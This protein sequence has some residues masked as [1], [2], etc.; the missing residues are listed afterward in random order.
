MKEKSDNEQRVAERCSGG[1]VAEKG[2]C[3]KMRMVHEGG[4][5]RQCMKRRQSM[6]PVHEKEAAYGGSAR[7]NGS[8]W[9]QCT[10][11][12]HG[13]GAQR[14]CAKAVRKGRYSKAGTQW[15]YTEA[16]GK[17]LLRDGELAGGTLVYENKGGERKRG[18]R[19]RVMHG[20][21]A[22]IDGER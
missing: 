15:R 13:D 2:R 20:G 5:R 19:R 9:R 22:L 17:A 1:G 7:E 16:I 11:T 21:N 4:A 6:E 14:R 18:T 8:V 10:E 3:T 12:V